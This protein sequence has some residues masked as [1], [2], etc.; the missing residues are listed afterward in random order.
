MCET[1]GLHWGY[2]KDDFH[3]SSPKHLIEEVALCRQYGANML[4]NVGPKGDGTLRTIDKGILE[5][6]GQWVAY[7]GEAIR[8]PRPVKA[9][10]KANPRDFILKDGNAYY[11]F[12]FD[13]VLVGDV[14]V[15][16]AENPK[17]YEARFVPSGRV[18]SACWLDSGAPLRFEQ[19][20]EEA[21]IH[22]AP[23][24]YGQNMVVR[25]AKICVEENA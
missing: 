14:N 2:A 9:E 10:L 24:T 17:A 5:V 11:L 18:V 16:I 22:T 23:Y 12:C 21:V 20:G 6:V 8:N 13:L 25:V 4:L 1:M 19:D 3:F 15:T 7:N